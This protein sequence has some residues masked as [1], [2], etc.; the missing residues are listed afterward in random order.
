MNGL[1][2][3]LVLFRGRPLIRHVIDRI[4]PQVHQLWIN[5]NRSHD[6]YSKLGCPLLTDATADYQG[7]LAGILSI[8][9]QFDDLAPNYLRTAIQE[10]CMVVPCDM[11]FLPLD[12]VSRLQNAIA[13]NTAAYACTAHQA[14]PLVLL[15]RPHQLKTIPEYLKQG[16]RSVMGWLQSINAIPVSFTP[17]KEFE[18]IGEPNAEGLATELLGKKWIAGRQVITGAIF[19]GKVD[20]TSAERMPSVVD[21]EHRISF[22]NFNDIMSLNSFE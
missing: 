13:A 22:A 11:P 18:G 10:Y 6:E 8:T 9:H 15:I 3:G 2:K 7:P 1:D 12:L 20:G 5:C 19:N 17:D 14:Q 4:K 16:G 21:A